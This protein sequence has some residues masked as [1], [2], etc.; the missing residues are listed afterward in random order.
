VCG[1]LGAGLVSNSNLRRRTFHRPVRR[2]PVATFLPVVRKKD[3]RHVFRPSQIRIHNSEGEI[4][5]HARSGAYPA[6]YHGKLYP[7]HGDPTGDA[8]KLER[9]ESNQ[10]RDSRASP[11]EILT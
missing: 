4:S 5:L 10:I 8:V 2:S 9:I 7:Y 3:V 1:L 6:R 11:S